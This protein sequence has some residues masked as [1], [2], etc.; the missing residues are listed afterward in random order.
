MAGFTD[1]KWHICAISLCTYRAGGRWREAMRGE[2][3]TREAVA[4]VVWR[5]DAIS[6]RSIRQAKLANGR[7]PET[8]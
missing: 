5:R 7:A 6:T 4:P 3:A 8:T 1:H 2:T